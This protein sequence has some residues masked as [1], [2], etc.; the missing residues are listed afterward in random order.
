MCTLLK[1]KINIR[2]GL[3][4]NTS[5]GFLIALLFAATNW[6]IIS[7]IY[8][9]F[10]T[11]TDRSYLKYENT[12]NKTLSLWLNEY[13]VCEHRGVINF[14]CIVSTFEFTSAC[15]HK[16]SVKSVKQ[17]VP[18]FQFALFFMLRKHRF[19]C[20]ALCESCMKIQNQCT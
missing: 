11:L 19:F 2:I 5:F 10:L 9:F 3:K 12:N 20:G 4:V 15:N 7:I 14:F 13:E 16:E 8:W 17:H 6:P 1:K 18:K